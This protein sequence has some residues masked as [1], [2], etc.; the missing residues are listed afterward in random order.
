ML[1]SALEWGESRFLMEGWGRIVP[2]RSSQDQC[3]LRYGLGLTWNPGWGDCPD[4][5]NSHSGGW[6]WSGWVQ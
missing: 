6:G 2:F 4:G 5:M 3:P 1:E